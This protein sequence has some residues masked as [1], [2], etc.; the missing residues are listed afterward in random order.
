VDRTEKS[1]RLFELAENQRG[2]F[3]SADAKR[4]GYDYPHQHFHVNQA[5]GYALTGEFSGLKGFHQ[6][7]TK[8]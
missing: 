8:I 2:Y 3:T 7:R 6:Q 1:N 5:T 4:L